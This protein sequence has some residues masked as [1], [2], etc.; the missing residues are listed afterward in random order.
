VVTSVQEAYDDGHMKACVGTLVV[1]SSYGA[2]KLALLLS[3]ASLP[4][5]DM[6]SYVDAGKINE[7][8]ELITNN[9]FTNIS[10]RTKSRG[11]RSL[12]TTGYR[13]QVNGNKH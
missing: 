1:I 9:N 3:S 4:W 13:L 11:K 12:G 10:N 5:T 8:L 2:S 6:V 7:I